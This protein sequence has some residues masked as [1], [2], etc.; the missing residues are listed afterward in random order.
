[1]LDPPEKRL[2]Q[3]ISTAPV[4]FVPSRCV[5]AERTSASR[6]LRQATTASL[7]WL[8]PTGVLAGFDDC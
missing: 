6:Q 2:A 1:M 5:L 4:G 3:V 7:E 8:E